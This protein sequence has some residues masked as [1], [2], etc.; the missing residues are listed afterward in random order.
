[1]S[2]ADVSNLPGR[3]KEI[4]ELIRS[5]GYVATEQLVRHFGVT[6]QTIR[7][8]INLLCELDLIE[9]FHG[10]AGRIG[11]AY[12]QPYQDR[13][14]EG[15]DGKRKIAR[16]VAKR[17]PDG[18]SLFLNIGTTTEAIAAELVGRNDLRIVTN[19]INIANMM[20]E[21]DGSDVM[22][23]GGFVRQSDG[24]I[25]GEATTEFLKQFRLDIG[26]IGISG[27]DEDGTLLDFDYQ[28][29]RSAQ[30]IIQNSRTVFLVADAAKFGR[31][32]MVRLGDYSDIDHLYTDQAPPEAFMQAIREAEME[33]HVA[34][35]A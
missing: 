31:R 28:E 17:I 19:N 22:I 25:V 21:T 35:D 10:G 18:A 34:D 1:M 3:Q 20:R 14:Q 2:D 32:A 29:I 16:M 8:D 12:N 11:N 4:L 6:P 23:A 30:A 27:I 5:Q 24:G 13:L 15:M 9:R 26:V 33:L 7:R